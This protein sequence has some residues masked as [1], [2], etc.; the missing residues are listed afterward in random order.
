MG[1]RKEPAC[2]LIDSRRFGSYPAGGD[3]T[4]LGFDAAGVAA[5]GRWADGVSREIDLVLEIRSERVEVA[6]R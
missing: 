2:H 6:D 4:H 5:A 3:G 1:P